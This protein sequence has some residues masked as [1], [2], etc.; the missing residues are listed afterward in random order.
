MI[1]KN[2]LRYSSIKLFKGCRLK[3]GL[4][5][6]NRVHPTW[7]TFHWRMLLRFIKCRDQ[8]LFYTVVTR[9]RQSTVIIGD[10]WGLW[11]CAQKRL[12]DKQRTFLSIVKAGSLN[13]KCAE[14]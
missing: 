6:S 13:V 1:L 12:I 7:E 8:N 9:A 5:R 10:Q 2:T 4:S 3:T 11:N 14:I